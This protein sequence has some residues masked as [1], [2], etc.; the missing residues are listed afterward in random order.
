[1][2]VDIQQLPIPDWDLTCPRCRY[3]LKCLTTH[4]CPECGLILDME[5]IVRPWVR[6]RPP[7]VTGAERPLLD[8]G[9]VC[10]TCRRP[11]AG[12]TVDECPHCT[13][14]FVL[15]APPGRYGWISIADDAAPL[16]VMH[17]QAI[18]IDE[19]VPVLPLEFRSAAPV[20]FFR[21]SQSILIPREYWFEVRWLIMQAAQE[22]ARERSV[23]GVEWSCSKCGEDVPASFDVCWNC[24]TPRETPPVGDSQRSPTVPDEKS[25]TDGAT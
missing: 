17:L 16:K 14:P 6:L 18:L 23:P 22:L 11:L 13:A 4:R 10:G 20:D 12:A 19:Q 1:M 21:H 25:P 5:K 24:E 9:L 15:T 3:A 8:Y 7:R 2:R